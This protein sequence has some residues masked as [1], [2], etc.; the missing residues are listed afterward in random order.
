MADEYVTPLRDYLAKALAQAV[1]G[2][3]HL[4]CSWPSCRCAITK[5]KINAVALVVGT[6]LERL[7]SEIAGA[8]NPSH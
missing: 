6:E 8:F 7:R 2:D 1:C 4:V 3:D 5:Q